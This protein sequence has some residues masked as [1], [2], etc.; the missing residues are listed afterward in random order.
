[1]SGNRL[2]EIPFPQATDPGSGETQAWPKGKTVIPYRDASGLAFPL[3][4]LLY[5]QMEMNAIEDAWAAP[6][7]AFPPSFRTLEMN[8]PS[9][10]RFHS[11]GLTIRMNCW[12]KMLQARRPASTLFALLNAGSSAKR[13]S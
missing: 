13:T 11:R 5:H 8:K 2:L 6:N 10:L 7:E 4:L 3:K 9:F 12:N 1:M